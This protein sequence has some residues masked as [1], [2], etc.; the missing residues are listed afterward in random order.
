VVLRLT[1]SVGAPLDAR[2]DRWS[3]VAN[4][5][6][7]QAAA[8]GPLCLRS[9]GRQWR[10]F[11][12]LGEVCTTIAA[13]ALGQ[14]PAGTYNLGS[15]APRTVLELAE[16]VADEAA[17]RLSRRPDVEAPEHV[18]PLPEAVR[19]DVSRLARHVP[20][21]AVPLSASVGELLELCIAASASSARTGQR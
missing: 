18:G 3:L 10:D 21:P 19:V 13:A 2:V 11:V 17:A 7:R 1:N 16:V 4:D 20:T 14:V 8:G 6:C 15:G 12:D 5:L 9:S